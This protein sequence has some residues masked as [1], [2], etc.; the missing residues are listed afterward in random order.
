M[1]CDSKKA[2]KDWKEAK[3]QTTKAQESREDDKKPG[4]KQPFAY[5]MSIFK[6]LAKK[7]P[8]TEKKLAASKNIYS[9][10]FLKAH[11]AS[12]EETLRDRLFKTKDNQEI[13]S[14]L[15]ALA[16]IKKQNEM[17]LNKGKKEKVKKQFHIKEIGG[18]ENQYQNNAL[19]KY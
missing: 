6:K 2:K 13:Q 10:N 4:I 7:K 11:N 3:K 9:F 8:K 18:E 17:D 5:T 12:K 16:V 19:I 14:I 15:K 1:P